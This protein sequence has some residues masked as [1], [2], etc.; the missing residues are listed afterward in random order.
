MMPRKLLWSGLY[1]GIAALAAD[2][3]ERAAE[4]GGVTE[5]LAQPLTED[6]DLL[7]ELTPSLVR[8]RGE[9][10]AP[11]D[12]QPQPALPPSRG[13]ARR[14]TRRS[15]SPFI[16]VGAA[17]AAGVLLAKWIDWRSHAHPHG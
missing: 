17:L 14:G 9:G 8:T 7:S 13:Q 11:S 16:V 1:A 15:V 10:E 6:A 3:S 12:E 4:R 5:T 2:V